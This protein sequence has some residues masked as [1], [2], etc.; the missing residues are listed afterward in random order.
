M[1][2]AYLRYDL[3]STFGVVA[4]NS[5][6]VYDHSG[7]LI[8]T[9]SLEN[10]TIW[11]VKQ[12]TLVKTLIT[13]ASSGRAPA[14]VTQI[15][16]GRSDSHQIAVGHADGMVRLWNLQ[17][18]TCDVTLSGHKG[19]VTALKY[20]QQGGL[21][22]S[23]A[24]DTD[25][26]V[27]DV[28][29]ESG[30]Y[31]LRGHQDQIT[32]L[33]FLQ[34]GNKLISCSKDSHVRVWDLDTQHCSQTL[35]GYRGEVWA[36]AL[37][38]TQS[39]LVTGSA[40]VDLQVYEVLSH[41]AAGKEAGI[42]GQHD[43][44]KSMGSI[45]RQSTD[46]VTRLSFD[47]PGAT[48]AC[49]TTG[50][51][52]D[53]FKVRSE[54]EAQEHMRRRRKRKREKISKAQ[55]AADPAEVDSQAASLA[56]E[57]GDDAAGKEEEDE[58]LT[59]ADELAPMQTIR[60][61]Q[62]IRSFA[63]AP[64][65]S[66]KGGVSLTIA[67][68]NNSLEVWH[69]KDEDVSRLHGL[70]SPGHRS[71]IR[72][73]AL[74]SDDSLLLSGSNN[75]VKIWN[76]RSGV[77]LRTIEAGYGL[78]ALFAPGNRHAVVGT[79]EGTLDVLDVGASSRLQSV[80]AHAGAVWSLAALPDNSGFVS[81]SADKEVKF[82]E[83]AI[84]EQDGSQ[85]RQLTV[86]NTRTL[87]MTDEVLCVRISPNGKLLAVSLLDF[88]IKV[89]FTDSLKF[90]LSLYGHKLPVL[91]MDISSDS[92]LLVS[93]AADKNIKIWGLD[94]GDCHRSLFAHADSVMQV[95]FVHNT[96]YVFTA[97]K[98]KVVKYW[99]ADKFEQLLTLEGHHGEVWCMALSAHGDFL[100]TGSHDRS[101]RRW[102]RTDEPF[103]VEEER[104]KR[105]E[106]LFEAD[107]EGPSGR[108]NKGGEGMQEGSVAPAGCKTLETLGAADSI[109]EALEM[110]AN[111][112][113]SHEDYL[114]ERQGDP[115]TKPPPPNPLM[116]GLDAGGYV[117]KA[118][119]S[120]KA[121]DLEQALLVLPF[122]EALRLLS[123][124]CQWLKK[125]LQI[126]FMDNSMSDTKHVD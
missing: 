78:C 39:R 58:K 76:P 71:D 18:G 81:G 51:L 122:T 16:V 6:V 105:L 90:F 86:N 56:A 118:V 65:Q 5:N 30:L 87:K 77:C 37:D 104:E 82:W 32:D 31:R 94:F 41:E 79:K 99:D 60:C 106:S 10:I 34:Q 11:N 100:V 85:A 28:A 38:A 126:E 117:L 14:E 64:S 68:A 62:K 115:S 29:A 27:W 55:D 84:V 72:T 49:Q 91:S 12:G 70:D 125:G 2:K 19:Q 95:A 22:A 8:I 40:D 35:V 80:E 59:A 33:A 17:S 15:A 69:I 45:R 44:L 52:L 109:A 116:M 53:F 57:G 46:R 96:H 120:V 74:S 63:L 1:V 88:T 92:T 26:I 48:L 4:S 42:S 89:F 54:S 47:Q 123:Y 107:L 7:K 21:L 103:F 114:K 75:E 67:L 9:A 93:G 124:L 111:E 13:P 43:T 24:Q 66:A 98:D 23:G 97:G 3:A 119:G 101:L 113:K 102:E 25:I 20:N 108:N 110:A 73:V 121:A 61:K 50:K 36:L 112:R 83:W